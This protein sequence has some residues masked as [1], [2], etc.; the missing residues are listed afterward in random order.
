MAKPF[1]KIHVLAD[2]DDLVQVCFIKI[3]RSIQDFDEPPFSR[4]VCRIAFCR[5]TDEL[6]QKGGRTR[7]TD[8]RPKQKQ[9]SQFGRP[10]W[11][12]DAR[13][14]LPAPKAASLIDNPL[15][16]VI[17]KEEVALHWG[18][19]KPKPAPVEPPP[20]EPE[21]IVRKPAVV[22]TPKKK[23]DPFERPVV[24]LDRNQRFETVYEAVADSKLRP[25]RAG[26]WASKASIIN[27]AKFGYTCDG[28][29]WAFADPIEAAVVA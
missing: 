10:D 9:L 23:V 2:L 17:L 15:F 14:Y 1:A 27:A 3:A 12:D 28:S 7:A 29:K 22:Y 16:Q 19:R 26:C 4:F 8:K 24:R 20:P 5:I 25:F 6:R 11:D 18:R 13:D 21:V